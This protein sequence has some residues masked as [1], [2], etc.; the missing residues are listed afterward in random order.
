[1]QRTFSTHQHRAADQF[2][3][4]QTQMEAI[5]ELMIHSWNQAVAALM[6]NRPPEHLHK[7][8]DQVGVA[9]IWSRDH[10]LSV[11]SRNSDQHPW[12]PAEFEKLREIDRLVALQLLEVILA[13]A[14]IER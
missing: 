1:M 5:N 10:G 13:D 12:F 9:V 4:L 3:R 7:E 6:F 11:H 14:K 8:N 2:T